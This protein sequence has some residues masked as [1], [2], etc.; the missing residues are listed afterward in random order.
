MFLRSHD[1][2]AVGA[3]DVARLERVAQ[4]RAKFL[5]TRL[6]LLERFGDRLREQQVGVVG[7][8][9]ERRARILAVLRLVRDDVVRGDLLEGVRIRKLLEHQHG[10]DRQ[11]RAVAV[12]ADYAQ[13]VR[14][15]DAVRLVDLALVAA[16]DELFLRRRAGRS[17]RGDQDRVRIRRDELHDD[18]DARR[19]HRA[20]DLLQPAVAVRVGEADVAHRLHAVCLHVHRDR[21]RHQ[22]V[23]LRRL[24]HPA[25]LRVGGVDNARR[26][27]HRDHRRL[28]VRRDVDH[29]QRVR[30]DRRAHDHIDLVLGD[31]L[32][33]VGDGL[34][35][36]GSVVEH[37][38]VHL[39]ARD[40]LRQH[41]ERVLYICQC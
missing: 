8:A 9:A 10:A 28:G 6:A 34:R 19:L 31:Q 36:I 7:V 26:R 39:L 33:R 38:P 11:Q 18:L 15:R 2:H 30:R 29:R 21:V 4:P 20:L 41:F 23:V 24:E 5:R 14:V 37:D 40:R 12:L 17:G 3:D 22:R 27:R 32:A 16:R 13:E 25:H 35:G 1:E